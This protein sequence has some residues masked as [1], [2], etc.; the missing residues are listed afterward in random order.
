MGRG[1]PIRLPGPKQHKY[2]AKR[3]E[4]D[5]I[6]FASQKEAKRYQDLKLLQQAGEIS[7]LELQPEFELM[8]GD[9]C[10]CKYVADFRYRLKQH[11][12]DLNPG[13]EVVEDVKGCNTAVYR[14]K[15]KLM[16]A[17][18]GIEIQEV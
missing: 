6:T 15:K 13:E 10:V 11:T 16:K 3:T 7:E 1:I 14:L 12:G 18:Y 17:I 2:R 9:T 8:V 4:V 5:G